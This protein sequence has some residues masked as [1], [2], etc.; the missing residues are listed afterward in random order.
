MSLTL[1]FSLSLQ[2]PFAATRHRISP[3]SHQRPPKKTPKLLLLTK[4]T[5]HWQSHPPV[6]HKSPDDRSWNNTY[7]ILYDRQLRW[8]V[9]NTKHTSRPPW[10]LPLH[11]PARHTQCLLCT[12]GTCLSQWFIK[13]SR[14]TC[15][16]V[17]LLCEYTGLV[18]EKPQVATGDGWWP[19]GD[20]GGQERRKTS[21]IVQGRQREA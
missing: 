3:T 15:V 14:W 21:R 11:L 12:C 18:C 8:T 10:R 9:A 1:R 13:G 17:P 6:R 4:H 20:N 5:R 7:W 16:T 19:R 2:I